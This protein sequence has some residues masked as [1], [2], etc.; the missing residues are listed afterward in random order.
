MWADI[1]RNRSVWSCSWTLTF[2]KRNLVFCVSILSFLS[3]SSYPFVVYF[4]L[5][6]STPLSGDGRRSIS[7][8]S[9]EQSAG[10]TSDKSRDITGNDVSLGGCDVIMAEVSSHDVSQLLQQLNQSDLLF[11]NG[12]GHLEDVFGG[13]NG[14]SSVGD[15]SVAPEHFLHHVWN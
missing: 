1:A 2:I 15:C 8:V 10:S 9:S 4:I 12:G 3:R 11:Q 7:S 13:H 6:V 5:Q 14:S